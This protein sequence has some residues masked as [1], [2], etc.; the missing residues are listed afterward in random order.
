[1]LSWF[2]KNRRGGGSIGDGLCHSSASQHGNVRVDSRAKPT[3]LE[4]AIKASETDVFRK[5]VTFVLG[6][7]GRKVC[8]VA[9]ILSYMA[10][11]RQAVSSA[12]GP[13]FVFS[14]GRALTRER[15]V[16]ELRAALKAG[17]FRADDYV[18]HSFDIGSATT[19]TMECQ[20]F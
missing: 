8:P 4:V 6:A 16:N 17:G 14:D 2:L 5:G 11:P 7:I 20:I 19:A 15:F 12:S 10:N 3:Y 18:G 9:T 13:F 1:M